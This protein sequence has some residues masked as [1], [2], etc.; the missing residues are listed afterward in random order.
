MSAKLAAYE[1]VPPG[2]EMAIEGGETRT[3]GLW[4]NVV[5]TDDPEAWDGEIRLIN[6]MQRGLG[7]LTLDQRLI[8]AQMAEL[9]RLHPLFPRSVDIL[10]EEIG[11]GRFSR[12]VKMGCE[13][14]DLLDALGY[15]DPQSLREQRRAR[16][17]DYCRALR[18][19]LDQGRPETPT[20]SKVFGFLG[21]S[22]S[23]KEALAEEV[24]SAIES[25]EPLT[26]ALRELVEAEC[27]EAYG[28]SIF[29]VRARL[30][31][32]FSCEEGCPRGASAP[33]CPC[34][35]SMF[36]DAGLLCAR[37]FDDG[38]SAIDEFRRF[39]EE[40]VL[41]YATAI[42]SWLREEPADPVT[43]LIKSRYITEGRALEIPK[44]VHDS[45]GVKDEAKA[46][47]AA[48]LLKTVKDNQRWHG[49][50]ELIDDLP[51]AASWFREML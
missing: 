24:V 5:L 15:H 7:G 50:A 48:C 10:C 30:F 18:M 21:P 28:G 23:S 11:T 16:F 40:N 17:E 1:H 34:C 49:R 4:W 35:D 47:L 32:C 39:T 19:W 42:N 20:E 14:R 9:C 45:L 8:R 51:D 6:E 33:N 38:G 26:P 46:W 25:G 41:A 3:R 44:G 37:R 36:L 13:G 43:S 2:F 22:A 27:R 31:T 12:P 29:D